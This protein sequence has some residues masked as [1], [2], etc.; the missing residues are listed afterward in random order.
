MKQHFQMINDPRFRL[1]YNE[2]RFFDAGPAP[3]KIRLNREGFIMVPGVRKKTMVYPG[4]LLAE[5]PSLE[6]GDLHAPIH[7]VITE[8]NARSVFVEAVNPQEQAPGTFPE[9]PEPVNLLREGLEGEE[10][11]LA[12]KK[13]GVNT[14]SLG[15][16][17]RTLIV[18][19][20]N[21]EPGIRWAEPMLAEHAAEIRA[22]FE[23]QRRF[24]RA[25]EIML[26]VP[27]GCDVRFEGVR[28]VHV[29]PIY[30][31]SVN[32][33][34]I[35]E[36]T[37]MEAP[38]DVAAVSLH[39]VWS[40]GRTALTGLPLMETVITIGT[41][42]DWANYI[43]K[44]GSLVG[45]LLEFTH[46]SLK[47][48]DTILRGGPL[49]GESLDRLDRSITKGSYGFFVVNA[50]EVPP[51]EGDSPCINCGACIQI[52]P[53]RIDPRMLSRYAEFGRYDMSRRENF[54]LCIDCG[55]CGYVCIARR[56]V[57]QYIRLAVKKLEQEERL[58]QLTP[59]E[60]VSKA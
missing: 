44:N 30:P 57:L 29:D 59:I 13:M 58:S 48:G 2:H 8:V 28:T 12:V 3:R 40:L 39:N 20:L 4:M 60:P 37:G 1:V 6:K 10:L 41:A 9:P 5:H 22:G 42:G 21:P 50:G 17:V 14:R 52:C 11:V 15:R 56:P 31:N 25:D 53:T 36:V 49:R 43:V 34:M 35:K 47:S 46:I 24:G 55:L 32:E 54:R 38:P 7:G 16:R 33:L 45:E 18:N 27:A 26:A 51:I 19:G 23:L